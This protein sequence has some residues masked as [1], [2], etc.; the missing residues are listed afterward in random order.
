MTP[1]EAAELVR[2][3]WGNEPSPMSP[4]EQHAAR[5]LVAVC[6]HLGLRP[7]PMNCAHAGMLLSKLNVPRY[8]GDE[9]PKGLYET[10]RFGKPVSVKYPS[11]H[12][13]NGMD[14]VFANTEEEAEWNGHETEP[15][16]AEPGTEHGAE[17]GA[18][19]H[20]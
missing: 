4:E 17:H 19:P 8:T 6:E 13:K 1:Q 2:P 7:D 12:P 3:H 15:G 11:G 14:V 18:E 5:Y 20:E 16:T 10:D 9:Y